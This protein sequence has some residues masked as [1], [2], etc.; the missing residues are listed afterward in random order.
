[1]AQLAPFGLRPVRMLDGSPYSGAVN[2][3]AIPASDSTATFIGDV[4]NFHTEAAAAGATVNG[5]NLEGVPYVVRSSD[6]TI[7]QNT[8]GV[9]VGFLPDPTALGTK[10]RL[11]S[12]LRAVLVAPADGII[13]E[14]QEDAVGENIAK[15]SANLNISYTTTAGSTATG[16][17]KIALDSSAKAVTATLPLRLLGLA[18]RP[19]NAYGAST[20][21]AAVWE[22]YFNTSQQKPNIVGVA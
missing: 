22:V 18:K 11:A 5:M 15:E 12:T 16:V 8:A 19:G 6:G 3:M 4:V 13:Y 21:D 20:S 17:S 14:C 9:V 7:G 1:M 2:V 10:Y